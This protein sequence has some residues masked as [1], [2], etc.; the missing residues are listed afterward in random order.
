M[1]QRNKRADRIFASRAQ[2]RKG[3][4]YKSGVQC[5]YTLTLNRAKITTCFCESV[6]LNRWKGRAPKNLSFTKFHPIFRECNP[7]LGSTNHVINN[8]NKHVLYLHNEKSFLVCCYINIQDALDSNSAVQRAPTASLCA[9]TSTDWCRGTYRHRL[10]EDS[11]AEFPW[12]SLK[13]LERQE[14]EYQSLHPSWR[15]WGPRPFWPKLLYR[16]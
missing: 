11:V 12:F 4:S 5:T 16:A 2:R 8:T 7:K 10:R 14:K 15:K 13:L 1:R 6:P 3:R 9:A